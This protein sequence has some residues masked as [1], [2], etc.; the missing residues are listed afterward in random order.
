MKK[1]KRRIYSEAF[2]RMVVQEYEQ[3]ASMTSL[4]RKYG[5]GGAGTIKRWVQQFGRQPYR[6]E[7]VFIQT[8]E[9]LEHVRRLQAQVEQL[10][11]LVAEL[12]LEN[13]ILRAA[14]QEAGVE[15]K[16]TGMPS[17]SS[18]TEKGTSP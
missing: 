17:S 9:D 7:T 3:G 11:K 15:L 6:T 5:I 8:A 16:K 12:A 2:K 10:Q 4:Q 18:Y 14:L 13:R 1:H